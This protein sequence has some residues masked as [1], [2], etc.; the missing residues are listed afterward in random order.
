[1][2]RCPECG[3]T[4]DREKLRYALSIGQ[5]PVRGWD[6]GP[7]PLL[8]AF[9]YTCLRIWFTPWSFA[10]QFPLHC[11]PGSAARFRRLALLIA[12]LM[13]ALGW[14]WGINRWQIKS[15][16]AQMKAL[17]I[18]AA[19]FVSGPLVSVLWC[20]T[21]LRDLFFTM[22]RRANCAHEPDTWSEFIQFHRGFLVL[23]GLPLLAAWIGNADA[24]FCLMLVGL[25]F[26]WWWFSLTLA[27]VQLSAPGSN[28]IA[29]VM[30]LPV[31][32][33]LAIVVGGFI[34]VS[35]GLATRS[36]LMWLSVRLQG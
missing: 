22:L 13:C 19:T 8:I 18:F 32:T 33:A 11:R 12:F 1:M 14:I 30:L 7:R 25:V 4:F 23:T 31:I 3:E 20:E 28:R 35:L 15:P 21:L 17:V 29:A 10:R 36:A 5:G 9:F 34:M 27:V 24:E 6:D 16:L 26:A 2:N